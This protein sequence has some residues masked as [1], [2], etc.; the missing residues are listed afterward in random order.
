MYMC[1]TCPCCVCVC[2]CAHAVIIGTYVLISVDQELASL[3][4]EK[5]KVV[6]LVC[7]CWWRG[8]VQSCQWR[9]RVL[10]CKDR[11]YVLWR[12]VLLESCPMEA[13]VEPLTL[14]GML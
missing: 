9:A 7:A 12:H 5:R 6:S 13:Y 14:K 2:A 1:H 8:D 4:E 11:G 10:S 3:Q